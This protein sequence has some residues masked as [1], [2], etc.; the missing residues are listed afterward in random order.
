MLITCLVYAHKKYSKASGVGQRDL[1][2][3]NL[4]N[5]LSKSPIVP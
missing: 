2:S 1:I 5:D 4:Y 3:N